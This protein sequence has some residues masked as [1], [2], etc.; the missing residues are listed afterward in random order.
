MALPCFD[1]HT[2]GV[3]VDFSPPSFFFNLQYKAEILFQLCLH[4]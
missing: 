3:L 2:A 1:I 4:H